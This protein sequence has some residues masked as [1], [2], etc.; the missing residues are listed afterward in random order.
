MITVLTGKQ[1]RFLRGRGHHIKP[2]V[3]IGKQGMAS[4]LMGQVE[5]CLLAHELVKVK[6]LESCPMARDECAQVI[7]Q[8]TGALLAQQIGRTLLIYRPHP[9]EPVLQLPSSA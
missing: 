8:A 3:H 9:E 4:A 5:E 7:S 2:L 6:V 1:K